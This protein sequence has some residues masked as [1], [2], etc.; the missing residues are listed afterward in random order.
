MSK[1]GDYMK[2]KLIQ[3]V[4]ANLNKELAVEVQKMMD[5]YNALLIKV[6]ADRVLINALLAK[7]DLD[8]GVT[9]TDYASTGTVDVDY[10]STLKL[11]ID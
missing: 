1:I 9:D 8:A 4:K 2:S 5:N 3:D 6:D 7:L 11:D 10:S